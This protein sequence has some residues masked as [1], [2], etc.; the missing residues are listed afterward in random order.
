[1]DA[2]DAKKKCRHK[3]HV[4]V[5]KSLLKTIPALEHNATPTTA[6]TAFLKKSIQVIV[7]NN[8][9]SKENYTLFV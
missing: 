7:V 3:T 2:Q 6:S 5:L 8:T 4:T 1:M 9:V